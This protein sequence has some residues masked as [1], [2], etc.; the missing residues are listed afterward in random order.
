MR[1]APEPDEN[2]VTEAKR[3]LGKILFWD[4]Q[5]SSDDTVACGT[6][7]KPGA[8]G[9]DSRQ[10]INPGPDEIFGTAD[11]TIGSPGIRVLDENGM[12]LNDPIYGHDPQVTGR[13]APSFLTSQFADSNFWDGRAL[14]TFTDPLDPDNVIIE[15][16]G[17]LESQAVGPILSTAEM[18]QRGRQWSD[19]TAKLEQVEPLALASN[20]PSDMA[21]ALQGGTDYPGLF[22]DA[23]GD[24]EITPARIAMA[25]ASYE[26]TLVPNRTPW[27]LYVAGNTTA[28]TSDQ[29][30]GWELFSEETVCGN[31]HRPPLFSTNRF[32]TIGLRPLNEDLG[33]FNVT[34]NRNDRGRFKIPSLRNVGLRKSLMHVGWITDVSDALDFYNAGTNDTGHVQFTQNQSNIPGTNGLRIDDIDV[35][36]DDPES[37]ALIVE[38]LSNGLTDPRVAAETFP[39]DRPTLAGESAQVDSSNS[40]IR[41]ATTSGSVT[42]AVFTGSVASARGVNNSVVAGETVAINARVEIAPE[43]VGEEGNFYYVIRFRGELFTLD[44]EGNFVAWDGNP[45]NLPVA[46]TKSRLGTIENFSIADGVALQRGSFAVYVAYDTGDGVLRYNAKAIR[47]SVR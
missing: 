22:D 8:G 21:N 45:E 42:D 10:A 2:P 1:R 14:D 36:G 39:F 19:V 6:C 11:D 24:P 44:D 18:A 16:G 3:I 25:I 33:L 26:R 12:Q 5:L 34:G 31:C 15:E 7:H 38:F 27:D 29:I 46:A 47:F 32:A 23:F 13:A 17:A 37:R 20:L 41:G 43:D 40:D 28:M 9:S 35:F 4:E 30:A